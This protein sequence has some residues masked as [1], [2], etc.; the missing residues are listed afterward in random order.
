MRELVG[1]REHLRGLR[2]GAVDEDQGG[3][4]VGQRE[5]PK[6]LRVEPPVGLLPT[7]PDTITRTP[8]ASASATKRRSASVQVGMS[9]RSSRSN[10]STWRIRAAVVSTS[11]DT[12]AEPTNGSGSSPSA[13]AN[14]WYQ[15]W[16]RW[17]R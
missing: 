3:E 11:S 8:S 14:S 7:T 13:R 16:R 17:Q 1:E 2:V 15:S 6:L 5:P 4:V 10:P 12:L 9:R